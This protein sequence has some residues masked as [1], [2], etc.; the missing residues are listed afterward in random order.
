ME[1]THI[2]RIISS[3]ILYFITSTGLAQSSFNTIRKKVDLSVVRVSDVVN[4]HTAS[5]QSNNTDTLNAMEG[6]KRMR[7]LMALP[8]DTIEV[9]GNY[10]PRID[11]FTGKIKM[12]WGIDLRAEQDNVRSLMSGIVKRTGYDR[13]LGQY[14]SI[15]HGHFK[16][17]YGHLSKIMVRKGQKIRAGD[18]IGITG[19]TGRSTGE[20]LHL[21]LKLRN[22]AVDPWAYLRLISRQ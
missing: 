3:L 1:N 19:S 9:T 18:I 6:S 14:I 16:S 20:H 4:D 2:I 12:H 5:N 7:Q 10:G 13:K 17:T 8:L 21:S 22:R 11:P 15:T